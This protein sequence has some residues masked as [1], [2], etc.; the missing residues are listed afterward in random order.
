MD[1]K[2]PNMMIAGREGDEAAAF[3]PEL[4]WMEEDARRWRFVKTTPLKP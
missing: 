3:L 2:N 1:E 4:K